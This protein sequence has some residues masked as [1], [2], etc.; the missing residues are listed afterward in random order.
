MIRVFLW[1][2]ALTLAGLFAIM[3]VMP[4]AA[5]TPP[6]T[7]LPDALMA[8]QQRYG[9]VP[10]VSGLASN[11]SLM[12]ITAGEA[13]GWSVLLVTPDGSACMVAS[14]EAFEVLPGGVEG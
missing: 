7:S 6:C 12:I 11:G 9:E 5:Q 10:R 13:G 3:S 4:A 1:A 2:F 8:L 14:G